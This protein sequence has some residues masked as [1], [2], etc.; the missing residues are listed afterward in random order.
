MNN[1]LN[2]AKRAKKQPVKL[3]IY[4]DIILVNISRSLQHR[5]N[6]QRSSC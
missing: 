6:N 1:Q 3:Q 4:Y 5:V 2:S